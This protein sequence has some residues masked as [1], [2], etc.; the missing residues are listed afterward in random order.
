MPD[1][2]FMTLAMQVEVDDK[3]TKKWIT[4]TKKIKK[5]NKNR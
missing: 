2:L 1:L 3:V 5:Q 4:K